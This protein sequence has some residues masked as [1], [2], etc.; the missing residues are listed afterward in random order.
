MLNAASMSW[1]YSVSGASVNEA[2]YRASGGVWKG[3]GF[4]LQ[5]LGLFCL[6]AGVGVGM[7]AVRF[8]RK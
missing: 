6:L 5:E 1:L 8:E 7:V 4:G 2:F 3:V